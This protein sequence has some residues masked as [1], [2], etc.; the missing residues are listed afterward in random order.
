MTEQ[1]QGSFNVQSRTLTM[2]YSRTLQVK[3]YEPAM[4]SATMEVQ[5]PPGTTVDDARRVFGDEYAVLKSEVLRQHGLGFTFDENEKLVMEVFGQA[6]ATVVQM[7]NQA[8]APVQQPLQQTSQQGP[9]QLPPPTQQYQE[10]PFGDDDPANPFSPPPSAVPQQQAPPQQAPTGSV[11]TYAIW[12]SIVNELQA[13]P[14]FSEDGNKKMANWFD[15][16]LNKRN[17]KGPDFKSKNIPQ[18]DNPQYK[19]G[20]WLRDCPADLKA[21]LA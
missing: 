3:Q 20:V 14:G 21:F 18:P 11:D 19:M 15:N 7:P 12:Q 9:Q 16:R 13:S 4:V 2:T 1:Q 6:D 5:L 17:P 10:T 8:P